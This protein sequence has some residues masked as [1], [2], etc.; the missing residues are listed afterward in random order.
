MKEGKTAQPDTSQSTEKTGQT[1]VNDQCQFKQLI[2]A[3]SGQS[4]VIRYDHFNGSMGKNKEYTIGQ[5][6]IQISREHRKT[7]SNN[8]IM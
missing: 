6:V 3:M 8:S 2:W 5:L 4:N 7:I 1:Y